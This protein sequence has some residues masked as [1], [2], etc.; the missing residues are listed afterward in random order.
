MRIRFSSCG[1][2]VRADITTAS[3]NTLKLGMGKTAMIGSSLI[4]GEFT[5]TEPLGTATN[6]ALWNK[7]V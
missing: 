1:Q 4:P 6:D 3:P 7:S 5:R 2:H